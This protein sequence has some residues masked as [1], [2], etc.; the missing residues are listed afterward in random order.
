MERIFKIALASIGVGALVLGCKAL[1]AQVSGSTAL[2]SDALESVVNI[3][4][5]AIALYALYVAAKP[6]DDAHNYG[7]AK[8]ELI[9]AVAI[10]VIIVVTAL[11]IFDRAVPT[12]WHPKPFVPLS[13]GLGLGL[14]FNA[15][16]GGINFVWARCLRAA[17]RA[18]H[19][20]SLL[21]DAQHL[22][23][24]VLTSLG[25]VI[26]LL[27][28]GILHWPIIDPL[29]ALLIAVQ[30]AIMGG[31]TVLRSLSGLLDEAPPPQVMARVSALVHE[32]GNGA[33]EAH[34]FRVR[35]A[36]P[37]SFME[38]HLVV[39]GQM[40]VHD[41]HLICDQIEHAIKQELPGIVI[42][43]HLEPETKAK[44]EGVLLKR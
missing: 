27:I 2:L 17:G 9:S 42:T 31:Q 1:A 10:G 34:D 23:S 16:A 38:F 33:L 3:A 7:H 22:L 15:L 5:S 37:S 11:V 19:S 32:H 12:L 26:A 41:A 44:H 6:P 40:S 14:A 43:I 20:P 29:I 24:D 36:G 13:G 25:I 35:Q 4:A 18:W 39:P 21:A 8:A 30:I 28:A